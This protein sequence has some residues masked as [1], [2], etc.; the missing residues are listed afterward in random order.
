MQR[1][2]SLLSGVLGGLSLLV[3]PTG[4]FA[5]LDPGS[6]SMLSQMLIGGI[7]S[8]LY[9][10]RLYRQRVKGL[11]SRLTGGRALKPADGPD[12]HYTEREDEGDAA[13]GERGRQNR[14]A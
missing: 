2:K 10:L 9:T 13:S 14:A 7:A 3:A 5:Y 1:G 12:E 4:A 6:G 8:A 11:L